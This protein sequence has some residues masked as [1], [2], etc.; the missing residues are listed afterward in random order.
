MDPTMTLW[1][2]AS[3]LVD[4]PASKEDLD[5]LG[6]QGWELVSVLQGR[7][8]NQILYVFKRPKGV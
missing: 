6:A 1:E 2:Y 4:A 7:Q 8:T 3:I 5:K